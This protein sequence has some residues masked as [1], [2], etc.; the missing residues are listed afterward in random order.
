VPSVR[1][2]LLFIGAPLL[3]AAAAA[4]LVLLLA[5]RSSG[6]GDPARFVTGLVQEI[7]ANDYADAWTTLHPVHQRVATREAYI[8]CEAQSPIPGQLSSVSV[9]RVA[10]EQV[11]VAGQEGTVAGKAVRVKLSISGAGSDPIVVTTTSHAVA[12]AGHWTW[13]LPPERFAEY[14]AGRCPT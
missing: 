10:D 7:A 6:P 4:V 5:G 8:A 13:I 1:T 2:R 11:R 3:V 14:R 9:L 12:V